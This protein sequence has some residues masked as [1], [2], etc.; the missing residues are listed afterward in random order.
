MPRERLLAFGEE[1]LSDAELVALVVGSVGSRPASA[2]AQRLLESFGGLRELALADPWDLIHQGPLGM[3]G[4]CA[5]RASFVMG[6]RAMRLP[7]APQRVLRAGAD[8]FER[9]RGRMGSLRKETFV[10]LCLDG[11]HRVLREERVS[12]GT[13]NAAIVHPRDVY[14]PAL[15]CAAA[16]IVVAH[17]HPSGDP[18]PSAEDHAVTHRLHE[19]GKMAGIELLD[20]VILGEDRYFSFAERGLL[21]GRAVEAP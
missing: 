5:L 2:V 3:A 8:V 14:G 7:I 21:R 6:R 15:R 17:N 18:T 9:L 1:D 4:A 13:L 12:E 16:A 19:V 11:R 10:A 20:H